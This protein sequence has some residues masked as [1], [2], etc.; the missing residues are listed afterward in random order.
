M[1]TGLSLEEFI[2]IKMEINKQT[3]LVLPQIHTALW[4]LNVENIFLLNNNEL[5][6][7]KFIKSVTL[8]EFKSTQSSNIETVRNFSFFYDSFKNT[9]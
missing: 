5:F 2:N 9:S 4:A 6:I 8:E 3:L 1:N 7:S